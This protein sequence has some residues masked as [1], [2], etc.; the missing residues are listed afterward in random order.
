MSTKRD[1][2]EA[3]S[4]SR[5]RLVTAFVSGAPGGREVEP[6]RPG[7]MVVGGVAIAVLLVA[8]AAIAGA[9]HPRPP[10]D[11]RQPGLVIAKESGADYAILPP[12]EDA[13]E[14]DE[15]VLRPLVNTV[16][17]LLLFGPELEPDTVPIDEINKETVGRS[18][19]IY[20]APDSLPTEEQL[21]GTGWTACTNAERG[22]RFR[23]AADPG[24]A[25]AP[26]LGVPVVDTTGAH[27]VVGMTDQGAH[28]WRLPTNEAQRIAVTQ[29]IGLTTTAVTPVTSDWLA[30]FPVG[31]ALDRD[32]FRVGPRG[33]VPSYAEELG[34]ADVSV[35]GLVT[36][37]GTTYLVGAD[38]LV[39][40]DE[41]AVQVYT[42]LFTNAR[43][44]E[45]A[46]LGAR[47]ADLDAVWPAGTLDRL[48]DQACALLDTDTE[49]ATQV[50]LAEATSD[51]ARALGLR[52]QVALDVQSGRGA[53]VRAA[54]HGD[55][56]GGQ[57]FLIDAQRTRYRLGSRG[58]EA[59][60]VL[61][62]GGY[63]APTIP[64]AWV[65]PF[66]CGPELSREAAAEEPNADWKCPGL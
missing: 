62:Y 30:L 9:L 8:G 18:V 47:V 23:I 60:T 27:W 46:G 6:V 7:R 28:R 50:L 38:E 63:D 52:D 51:S 20:D 37:G 39:E 15:V 55:E 3:H 11:W 17:A 36:R 56:D 40:L 2:V 13:A 32:T 53:Y 42:G 25:S 1:L 5:R 14:S 19:G 12:A 16:S 34:G 44:A 31:A 48:D 26:G 41:F 33:S 29:Q 22:T 65:E 49:G 24:A 45:I 59:A 4:F 35:G 64:D 57:Q 66:R 10:A 21:I 58:T 54:G 61:G 43:T